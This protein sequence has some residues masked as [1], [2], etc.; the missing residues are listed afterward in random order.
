MQVARSDRAIRSASSFCSRTNSLI[1]FF[2][3]RPAGPQSQVGL[4]YG[5]CRTRPAVQRNDPMMVTC[6]RPCRPAPALR[7]DGLRPGLAEQRQRG[8]G[9]DTA[10][11]MGVG[12]EAGSNFLMTFSMP[13]GTHFTWALKSAMRACRAERVAAD[14]ANVPSWRDSR[15]SCSPPQSGKACVPRLSPS[16]QYDGV[17][18]CPSAPQPG[19]PRKAPRTAHRHV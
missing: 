17:H 7:D 19:P 15:S 11:A 12:H 18:S 1:S 3:P 14:P 8:A 2:I 6:R 9:D 4:A 16:P 13:G 10:A 5:L